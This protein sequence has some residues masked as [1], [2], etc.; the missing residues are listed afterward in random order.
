MKAKFTITLILGLCT[1]TSMGADRHKADIQ[2]DSLKKSHK[3]IYFGNNENRYNADSI[4]AIVDMFYFDQFRHFSDP[5]APYFLFLSKDSKLAM[6]IGGVVRMRGWYDWGGAMN[7]SGFIPYDISIPQNPTRERWLGST[8]A[9]TALF[10]RVI[11]ND[12]RFGLYQFYLE[13]NFNGYKARDF[14]LKKAYASVGD[15]T[16]GYTNSTFQDP[17]ANPPTVDAQGPNAQ[18]SNTTILIRYLH[19]FKHG[20]SLAGS[21]EMPNS[22]VSDLG[23]STQPVSD[24]FPNIAGFAQYDIGTNQHVRLS[25]LMRVLPYRDLIR[26]RNSNKIGWGAQLSSVFRIGS[27]LT[28][29]VTANVGKG[30]E[31]MTNELQMGDLDLLDDPDTPG[32]MYAP[33]AFGWFGAAQYHFKPNLFSTLVVGQQRFCPKGDVSPDVYKYGIYSALNVF[34]DITTRCEVGGEFNLGKRK[35]FGGESKWARRV[36][37]MVQFSF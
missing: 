31:S 21:V 7:T 25:G 23:K 28:F 33:T 15:F 18:I 36:S 20:F 17:I 27:P 8:P 29:Y 5:R 12:N 13:A 24:W 3:I 30:Y 32:K 1:L 9:G 2:T 10:F 11:G 34:W 26:E 19:K 14:H 4:R 16:I 35:N 37:L 22:Q 6:G